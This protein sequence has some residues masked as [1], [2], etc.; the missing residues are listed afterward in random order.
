MEITLTLKASICAESD[1]NVK[2]GQDYS[3]TFKVNPSFDSSSPEILDFRL[4]KTQEKL[5]IEDSSKKDL[6][7]DSNYTLSNEYRI[8]SKVWAYCKAKDLGSGA[9]HLIINDNINNSY[10]LGEFEL[11][12]AEEG[13]YQAGPFLIELPQTMEEG[14]TDLSFK[15]ADYCDNLSST[16]YDYT[17]YL[18]RTYSDLSI[19]L[20]NELPMRRYFLQEIKVGQTYE[21]IFYD[22]DDYLNYYRTFY[23]EGIGPNEWASGQ[24]DE[25]YTV[26]LYTEIDGQDIEAENLGVDENGIYKFKIQEYSDGCNDNKDI[27][28]K[29][30]LTDSVGCQ[31][32]YDEKYIPNGFDIIPTLN[33]SDSKISSFNFNGEKINENSTNTASLSYDKTYLM[34]WDEETVEAYND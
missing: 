16:S 21:D 27:L 19:N 18:S 30:L 24:S 9:D 17:L 26:A 15:L 4:A 5:G 23:V 25:D 20:Y 34:Q 1:S 29:V 12:D 10:G 2:I 31:Y 8:S 32:L 28:L 6:L 13:I 11:I 7:S 3:Y 22:Y 33:I 14:Q